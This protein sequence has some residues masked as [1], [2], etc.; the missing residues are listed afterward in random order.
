[1]LYTITIVGLGIAGMLT[2]AH[3]PI[4]RLSEILMIEG[5]CIGGDLASLYSGTVANITKFDVVTAFR[6]IPRWEKAAFPFL[7]GYK[8]TE[9]P[10][11]GDVCKQLI[12]LTRSD[13]HRVECRTATV[14]SIVDN[15]VT[16]SIHTTAGVFSSKKVI[17]CMG[18]TPKCLDIP[19]PAIPLHVALSKDH[20]ANNVTADDNV[21]VFGTSH[22]GTL[23]MKN[24]KEV[25]VRNIT[26]VYVGKT[27]FIFVRDGHSEG[28]KQESAAIADEILSKA[29]GEQTPTLMNYDD[30]G[31][32]FR[33]TT[34][35]TRVIYAYG[36]Q[37]RTI[38]CLDAHNNTIT[39]KH[40]P[41][42]ASFEG[43]ASRL[44][45]FGLGY[46]ST[47]T[48]NGATYPDI[49]FAGFITAIASALPLILG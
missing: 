36:F 11:L 9:C 46:P 31:A 4:E 45:G 5:Q 25:G 35:A 43:Y 1:M 2:L 47:Y 41:T 10:K 33:H 24:L 15:G 40:N 19:R 37:R 8:D 28:I 16:W 44:W 22:S 17:L 3:I 49:G 38:Q 18:G 13:L 29:W 12:A 30:F 34:L 27:P 7:D 6:R 42:D 14:S 26:G 21:V 23:V 32:V 39:L 48:A 20:L